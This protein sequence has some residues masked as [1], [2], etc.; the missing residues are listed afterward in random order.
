M[1]APV[2]LAQPELAIVRAVNHQRVIH[3]LRALRPTKGLTR[4]ARSHSLDQM[5]HALVGHASSDGTSFDGRLA[6]IGKFKVSGEVVSWTS[7]GRRATAA[8]VVRMWMTSPSHRA[9]LLN[10]RF[11]TFGV[12]RARGARGTWVTADLAA[13]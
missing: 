7:A 5:R 13:R 12:G 10:P 9:E 3:G 1:P 4:L 2:P 11:R 8:R 6:R